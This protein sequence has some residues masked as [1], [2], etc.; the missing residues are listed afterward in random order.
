MGKV[1]HVRFMFRAI[2]LSAILNL[3]LVLSGFAGVEKSRSPIL[4]RATNAIAAPPGVIARAL[5]AP[6]QHTVQAFALAAAES[7]VCSFV[8]YALFFWTLF[9]LSNVLRRYSGQRLVAQI[10]KTKDE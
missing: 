8:L 3:C 7:L 1:I 9:E 6:K 2:F 5:F 4:L 10:P